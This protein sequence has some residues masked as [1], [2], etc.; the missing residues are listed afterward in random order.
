MKKNFLILIIVRDKIRFQH[1]LPN[2]V[3]KLAY[4]FKGLLE[5]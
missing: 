1:Y 4:I 2:E 5:F 3:Q